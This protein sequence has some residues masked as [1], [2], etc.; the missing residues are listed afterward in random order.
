[1]IYASGLG[2][3]S[4]GVASGAVPEGLSSVVNPVSVSIGGIDSEVYF[5]GLAPGFVGLYQINV[6][7]PA[8]AALGMVPVIVTA[9]GQTSGAAQLL[10]R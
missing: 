2:A 8:G 4:P 9:A 1:V 10:V 7:V 5:A 3:V 6:R